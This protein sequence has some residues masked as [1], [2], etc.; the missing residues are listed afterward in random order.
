MRFYRL[1]RKRRG[2][3][4]VEFAVTCPIALFLIFST[5]IGALGSF[6]YQQVA[7]LAR[8]GALWAS[9]HGSEDERET[10]QAAATPE[11]I[12]NKVILPAA[13]AMD[14]DKLSCA[15]SWNSCNEPLS[16]HENYE[17]PRGNTVTVT[18]TYV[19]FPE[20]YLVGPSTLSSSSTAQMLY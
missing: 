19:W 3:S 17:Q 13:V 4:T 11:D 14:T 20:V 15:V 8:E 1:A 18:V 5:V 2:T 12:F 10:D 9:V 6:R 7:S 16:V